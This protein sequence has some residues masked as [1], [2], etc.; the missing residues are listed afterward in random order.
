MEHLP[1]EIT[2]DDCPLSP[3][4]IEKFNVEGI[5][6]AYDMRE[7][8]VH[9]DRTQ[10]KG[11]GTGKQLST[12]AWLTK[13]GLW[14]TETDGPL[15]PE[16]NGTNGAASLETTIEPSTVD[17][18]GSAPAKTPTEPETGKETSGVGSDS[19]AVEDQSVETSKPEP[20]PVV[21]TTK[22]DS[23]ELQPLPDNFPVIVEIVESEGTHAEDPEEVAHRHFDPFFIA[24]GDD[25]EKVVHACKVLQNQADIAKSYKDA[26]ARRE[27]ALKTAK[28]VLRGKQ[29]AYARSIGVH[30]AKYTTA[31]WWISDFGKKIVDVDM[32]EIPAAILENRELFKVKL[33]PN[34]KALA[35]YIEANGPIP[36]ITLEDD[37]RLSQN[38]V[39]D[40]QLPLKGE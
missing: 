5:E 15:Y 2:L 35:A 1:K 37:H 23:V 31:Q 28:N 7:F 11:F 16:N 18:H 24:S 22:T 33:E 40:P 21:A 14:D 39:G 8:M 10:I 30:K 32:D 20:A 12:R 36:G 17:P 29:M 38:V 9:G 6:D 27:K 25:S 34:K 3:S 4:L 19:M 13:M 26:W